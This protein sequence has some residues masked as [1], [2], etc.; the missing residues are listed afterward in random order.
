[1]SQTTPLKHIGFIL[2]GNRRWAQD[3]GLPKLVGHKKGYDNLKVIAEQCFD[4]GIETVS[5]Y[6][7][8]TEN[9]NRELE[10]VNYLMDLA[11]KIF[12]SDLK[13]LTDKGIKVVVSGNHNRL[14]KKIISAIAKATEQTS[15][16]TKGTINLC[17]NYGGQT[18]IVDAVKKIITN[19]T[20]ADDVT[21]ELIREN[22]YH[23]ELPPVDYI[24]RTSGEQRLSNFLLWDSAYAEL[25]F[26]PIHWP[27]F[28]RAE[29]DKVIAVYASRM[30]RFGK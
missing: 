3:R 10:E 25:H 16:N 2:D 20:K 28:D 27:D 26:V 13:E 8:S 14:D 12:T 30:R 1:M 18:E 19:G 6:I 29:L 15:G 23:P 4:L 24:I 21:T 7:F 11:L 5:A 22:L 17:F 9:W